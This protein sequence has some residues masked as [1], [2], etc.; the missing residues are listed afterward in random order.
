MPET[1]KVCLCEILFEFRVVGI[2]VLWYN[3]RN[4]NEGGRVL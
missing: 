2:V 4:E 3:I 1:G